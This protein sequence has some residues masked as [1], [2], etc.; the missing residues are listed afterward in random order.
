MACGELP[1]DGPEIVVDGGPFSYQPREAAVRRHAAHH[2]ERFGCL[3]VRAADFSQAQVDVRGE[4]TV[5]SD[6]ALA[7]GPASRRG[8]VVQESQID[9]FLELVGAVTDEEHDG[10][11]GLADLSTGERGS[12]ESGAGSKHGEIP[13]MQRHCRP[14]AVARLNHGG[15][16]ETG[17]RA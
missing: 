7:G 11:V 1:G 15:K 14:P 17:Q 2:E 4:A 8:G 13:L 12:V 5:E 3:R 16:T 10:R 9:R 6:F